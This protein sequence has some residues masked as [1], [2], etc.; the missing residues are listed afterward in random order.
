MYSLL[1]TKHNLSL[2][3]RTT[4][5]RQTE[6]LPDKLR[7]LPLH[8]LSAFINAANSITHTELVTALNKNQDVY[9]LSLLKI[10]G[11]PQ[12]LYS[13]ISLLQS[14]RIITISIYINLSH[15]LT[16][17]CQLIIA[18]KLSY[19]QLITAEHLEDYHNIQAAAC[20]CC[21]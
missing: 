3:F 2:F 5:T 16:A 13:S 14:W 4:R 21:E 17:F 19:I 9:S 8:I 10:G 11:L 20:H 12:C 1:L 15:Q 6:N 18:K 7:N